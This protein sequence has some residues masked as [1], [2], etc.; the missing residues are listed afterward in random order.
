[1]PETALNAETSPTEL[2]QILSRTAR[3][4]PAYSAMPLRTRTALL[5]AVADALDAS[6]KELIPIAIEETHLSHGRLSGELAR[7]TF[8]L[9][10]LADEMRSG[11]PLDVRI[12]LPDPDWGSGPRPDLRAM[13]IPIG[14]VLNFA[15]G[16]FPFAFSVA[17]GDTAAALSAGCPVIVKAHPGHPQLSAATARIVSAVLAEHGAPDGTFALLTG[18]QAARAALTDHRI[19]AGAFTGSPTAGRALFDLANSRP[20]PIPFYAEMGGINPVFVTPSAVDERGRQIAQGLAASFALGVGQFCTSPGT[21]FVPDHA[22]DGFAAEVISAVQDAQP[23]P[24]LNDR[25]MQGY[26]E[27]LQALHATPGVQAAHLGKRSETGV[28]PSVLRTTLPAVLANPPAYLHECFGPVTLIV[29][30]PA[31]RLPD[32]ARL[33]TGELTATIHCTDPDPAAPELMA[34]LLPRVGR[35]VFNGWPTGVAVAHAMTHGG[36]YP[37]STLP[38]GTSVGTAALERFLRLVTIQ[39]APPALLPEALRDGVPIKTAHPTR[40]RPERR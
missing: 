3:A 5:D 31:G 10:L 12:D 24:M 2:E 26:L 40:T 15:A 34:L 14:P 18:D 22:A 35:L 7:T 13:R 32:A 8:Q 21:V 19:K 33:P 11:R 27:G 16:N 20:D 4:A 25:I 29:D 39:D 17:G 28:T 36:P 30:T 23:E 37:A 6:G 1:M 38:L 9:R